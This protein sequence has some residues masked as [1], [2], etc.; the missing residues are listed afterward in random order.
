M[1]YVTVRQTWIGAFQKNYKKIS[2]E[3]SKH[4]GNTKKNITV[5][6][7]PNVRLVRDRVNAI[8]G[9]H[10]RQGVPG[11]DFCKNTKG[12]ESIWL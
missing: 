9:E 10:N 4:G 7:A 8:T 11:Y 2:Y 1:E 6:N 12:L 3:A 5:N